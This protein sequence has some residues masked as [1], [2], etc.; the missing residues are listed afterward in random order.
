MTVPAA[1]RFY[2]LC[3]SLTSPW[4][5]AVPGDVP[6][7]SQQGPQ[8]LLLGPGGLAEQLQGPLCQKRGD[9]RGWHVRLVKRD[10]LRKERESTNSNVRRGMRSPSQR[11]R[12]SSPWPDRRK[13]CGQSLQGWERTGRLPAEPGITHKAVSFRGSVT[14]A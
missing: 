13:A 1:V 6:A 8:H 5:A 10:H 3:P 14:S 9:H 4:G 12:E 11:E 2:S 7:V